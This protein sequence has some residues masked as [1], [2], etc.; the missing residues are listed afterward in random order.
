MIYH[1]CSQSAK[2]PTKHYP[3]TK[4]NNSRQTKKEK[5]QAFKKNNNTKTKGPPTVKYC[6]V[7]NSIAS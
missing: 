7:T 6:T 5:K 4:E 3:G 1:Y 2:I